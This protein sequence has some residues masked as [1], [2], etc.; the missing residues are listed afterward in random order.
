MILDRVIIAEHF[1]IIIKFCK[2]QA[3]QAGA[4]SMPSLVWLMPPPPT[5]AAAHGGGHAAAV[6]SDFIERRGCPV[7]GAGFGR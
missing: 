7:R 6:T 5:A 1:T 2:L 3:Q 4:T